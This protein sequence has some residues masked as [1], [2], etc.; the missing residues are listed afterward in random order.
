MKT[1]RRPRTSEQLA[2]QKT[3]QPARASTPDAPE[4]APIHQTITPEQALHATQ[5][6]RAVAAVAP[7]HRP[8][9]AEF[10]MAM[11][12]LYRGE[13]TRANTWRNRLDTTTNWAVVTTGATLS[14]AFSLPTNPHFVILINT[15]L[16]GFFLFMEARRYRYYEIW[17]GRVRL[18]ETGFFMQMLSPD[19]AADDSKWARLLVADLEE[20]RFNVSEAEAL[21]RRLRRN[22]LWMFM[23]L[24]ASWNLK[25]YMHPYTSADF[26]DFMR[27]A[28]IGIVPGEV[29]FMVGIFF[30]VGLLLFA[31]FTMRLREATGE[32]LTERDFHPFQRV[33]EWTRAA[34]D[35]R[36]T[37][38]VRRAKRAR[39]RTRSTT[40]RTAGTATGE[41]RRSDIHR[42][43]PPED[44]HRTQLPN[45]DTVIK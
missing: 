14:F 13:V 17:S 30:N 29:V 34:A 19:T 42:S 4:T 31:F 11:V 18:L 33:G 25:V 15:V 45:R 8:T 43:Q 38:T 16:V 36:R 7:Q 32:V 35:K 1:D 3:V 24:A 26:A 44:I 37:A 27:K 2:P 39:D 9:P 23:L 41:W 21:G 5:L 6:P 40:P 12:H 22:Y 10:N 28:D 20:P